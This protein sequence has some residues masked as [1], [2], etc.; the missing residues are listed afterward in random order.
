MRVRELLRWRAARIRLRA[1]RLIAERDEERRNVLAV[2]VDLGKRRAAAL[3]ADPV[4]READVHAVRGRLGAADLTPRASVLDG[5]LVDGVASYVIVA[6]KERAGPEQAPERSIVERGDG[7][8]E[9]GRQVMRPARAP[10]RQGVHLWCEKTF[11]HEL[12]RGTAERPRARDTYE[13]QVAPLS[14]ARNG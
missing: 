13:G 5:H 8:G 10:G 9:G 11:C 1:A 6:A 2:P 3:G 7:I 14:E 4:G 12:G